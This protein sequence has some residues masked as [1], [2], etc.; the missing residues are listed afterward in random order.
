MLKHAC[1]LHLEG[2]VSK[3]AD[4]PY[5]SGRSGDWLKTKCSSNQEFIVIGYEPSDKRG[6]LIRSLLLGYYDKDAL[7][8]A[9]RVG[10]GWG[11][12][13][14]ARSAAKARRASR[15][16][17][18]RSTKFRRR[19]AGREVKWVEPKIVVEVDFRGWTGGKLVR[20]GSLKGVREDKPAKQVVREVEQMPETDQSRRRCGRSRRPKPA[21]Q[22]RR[23]E[24]TK[25]VAGC[26][27]HAEPSR[28]GLLGGR[29]RHQADAGRVLH[30]G[31]GLDAAA[32]HRPRAGAGALPRRR[33][34][35]NASSRSTPPPAS[36]RSI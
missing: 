25:P 26:R 31:L 21:R 23:G 24:V 12:A 36:T 20:Q 7:R 15:A 28:P 16:R 34:R 8:Y 32:C 6:R 1:N 33:Q 35:A 19:S 9:G 29:R 11:Q 14:G 18:R 27:R 13:A 30:A 17:T 2:I 3:R 4:A 5:R 10:T 22:S